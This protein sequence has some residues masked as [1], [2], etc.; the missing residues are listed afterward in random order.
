MGKRYSRRKFEID[1]V[2]CADEM[3]DKRLKNRTFCV[4]EYA[5]NWATE[6]QVPNNKIGAFVDDTISQY[7][8]ELI[9]HSLFRGTVQLHR[10]SQ[11]FLSRLVSELYES[12]GP[13]GQTLETF[14]ICEPQ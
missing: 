4:K 11:G 9:L 12:L 8:T 10:E 14:P 2:T 13:L 3:Y 1:S 6:H 5:R 7:H